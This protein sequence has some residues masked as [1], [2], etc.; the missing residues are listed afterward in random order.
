MGTAAAAAAATATQQQQQPK[1][2]I[3]I[4]Q[5]NCAACFQL[6]DCV[7]PT[8]VKAKSKARRSRRQMAI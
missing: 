5:C 6:V 2:N 8:G 3:N 1:S 4:K 7:T